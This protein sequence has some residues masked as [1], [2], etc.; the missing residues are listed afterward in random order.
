MSARIL[1]IDEDITNT[2]LL[3]NILKAYK[4][5]VINSIKIIDQDFDLIIVSYK[6]LKIYLNNLNNKTYNI[7]IIVLIEKNNYT[8]LNEALDLGVRDYI[9]QPMAKEEV[10]ARVKILLQQ[11][12]RLI[13]SNIDTL[14]GLYN[15]D[16]FNFQ[17]ETLL[18]NA[19]KSKEELSLIMIDLD[20]FRDINEAHGHLAGDEVLRQVAQLMNKEIR[21]T[22]ILSRFG[23]EEFILLL[24]NTNI[25]EAYIVAERIRKIIDLE[26]YKISSAKVLISNTASFGIASFNVDDSV[27]SLINRADAALYKAKHQGRNMIIMLN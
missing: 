9:S 14:T 1:I 6:L 16:Y 20:F 21:S 25:N 18:L 10:K 13:N 7:P 11:K 2:S 3:E 23:G 27:E 4:I 8:V 12:Q 22:D 26:L 17:I 19:R 24:P 5:V 15:K